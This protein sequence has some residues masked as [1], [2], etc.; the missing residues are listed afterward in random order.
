[1][2]LLLLL[3]YDSH[4]RSSP[5]LNVCE[6]KD[7]NFLQ[8]LLIDEGVAAV[9][10]LSRAAAARNALGGSSELPE[11]LKNGRALRYCTV[12]LISMI[13]LMIDI[14]YDFI[15]QNLRNSGSIVSI[16]SCRIY[17]M[18]RIMDPP[19]WASNVPNLSQPGLYRR[20]TC[21][22]Q[23]GGSGIVH[24]CYRVS[25]KALSCRACAMEACLHENRI[26]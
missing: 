14:L 18:N 13:L 22:S 4:Y 1:M 24:G 17:I 15:Y 11:A 5:T 19:C 9:D 10:A 2:Q 23:A 12:D 3:V 7:G 6:R 26:E 16:G 8:D 21:W 20:T 25:T